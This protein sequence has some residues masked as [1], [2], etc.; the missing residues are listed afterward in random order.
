MPAGGPAAEVQRVATHRPTSV[1]NKCTY[2]HAFH[3]RSIDG[4]TSPPP[5]LHLHLYTPTDG[6]NKQTNLGGVVVR[7]LHHQLVQPPLP[8]RALLWFVGV[9]TFRVCVFHQSH[10][11]APSPPIQHPTHPTPI[12]THTHTP[13]RHPHILRTAALPPLPHAP[14]RG[15]RSPKSSGSWS[16]PP[17]LPAWR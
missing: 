5:P 4:S 13:A 3:H 10:E 6:T 8:V 12:F 2:V 17:T 16:R 9:C 7:E 15:S 11:H 1:T 14:C